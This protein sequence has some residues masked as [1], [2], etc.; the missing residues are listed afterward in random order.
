MTKQTYA[1]KGWAKF[2]HFKDRK[3][4][5]I[6]LYRDLLDDLQWHTLEPSAAKFLVMLWLIASESDTGSLPDTAELAFRLRM[7]ERDVIKLI[8]RLDHWL[9][10]T[11]ITPIST[12]HQKDSAV[13]GLARSQETET[14][15]EKEAERET[16]KEA[17]ARLRALPPSLLSDYLKV[18]KA[19]RAGAFTTTAI[20]GM[21]R[22]AT[23]AGL[24][25]EQAMRYCC[26]AGWQGFNAG[27]Y[28]DRKAKTKTSTVETAYQRSMREKVEQFAPSIAA[29]QPGPAKPIMEVFDVTPRALG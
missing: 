2:Q 21:E 23:Q 10:R 18:R 7:Q 22:E 29:K 13:K 3:P 16:E 27:W 12:E 1:V 15:T 19:K 9:I 17:D 4:P 28:A 6:K 14:E 26:E 20:D 11:D 8:S 24:T 25:L 5:W